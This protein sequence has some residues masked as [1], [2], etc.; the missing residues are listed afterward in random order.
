MELPPLVRKGITS[1]CTLVE[2]TAPWMIR[3]TCKT[4]LVAGRGTSGIVVWLGYGDEGNF[5]GLSGGATLMFSVATHLTV[6]WQDCE[7]SRQLQPFCSTP[8]F[9]SAVKDA[10]QLTLTDQIDQSHALSCSICP[11]KP[12]LSLLRPLN[13]LPLAFTPTE[14]YVREPRDVPLSTLAQRRVLSIER[15]ASRS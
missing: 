11:P 7:S 14:Q 9:A 12:S 1:S 5:V 4:Q 13:C 15:V 6:L 2:D 8:C 3:R 10:V